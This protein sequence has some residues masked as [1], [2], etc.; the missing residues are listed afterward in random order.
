[1]IPRVAVEVV[2][3]SMW[4]ALRRGDTVLCVPASAGFA[5]GDVVCARL[6]GGGQVLH[7]VVARRAGTVVLQGDRCGEPDPPVPERAVLFCARV[8]VRGGCRR[9]VPARP[10]LWRVWRALGRM[11]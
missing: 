4:P 7:R 3:S 8:L 1:M 10:R 6:P 11:V 5:A 2:G 9:P